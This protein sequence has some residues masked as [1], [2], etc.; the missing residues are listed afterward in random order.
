[1]FRGICTYEVSDLINN[2]NIN[3][4]SIGIPTRCLKLACP[5][6]SAALA[7]VFNLSLM[8][9]IVPDILKISKVTPID[10]GGEA[11]DPFNYRPISTLSQFTQVFEKLVYK[12]LISYIEKH[13]ILSEFQFGFRKGH[14]TEQAITEIVD[15]FRSSVDSNQIVCGV[16]LD[17]A[18]AF[19]TVN[20]SIL[21]K[22]LEK[23]G[24]RGSPLQW[25]TSYLSNRQQYVSL[26]H[27]Q[28]STKTVLCG[29]PQGSTLGPLLFLL[30]INDIANS[31][32]KLSFRLFA[33]DTNVFTSSKS[34]HELQSIMNH[35]LI[36]VKNWC[37][38][39]KLSINLKK[40]NFLIIKSTR[41]KL[42]TQFHIK[43]PCSD[44]DFFLEQKDSIKYLGVLIDDKL[45]W[46]KHISFISSKIS[47]NTGVFFKLRHYLSPTQLRQLYY[48]LIYP[49][50]SY[51]ITA[52]GTST[53]TNIKTLQTKQNHVVRVIFFASLYGKNTDS[54]LPYLNLLDILTIENIHKLQV[55]KSTLYW[56]K[57][58]LPEIFNDSFKYAKNVHSYNTRYAAKDNFY[59][60]RFRTNI[61]RQTLPAT[62][63]ILW[64][65]LPS[66]FKQLSIFRFKKEVKHYLLTKQNSLN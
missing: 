40:T 39:N 64:Q 66:K 21:L 4:A 3:K 37:D 54:A 51:A 10:K 9:G 12:Q 36:L 22:K 52:W 11:A 19:D 16:F 25:F 13:N 50:L 14:S 29:I 26:D 31:S 5:N 57:N 33:D 62:A 61:G 53:K 28:S 32:K 45:N 44:T 8:Q 35:E 1:M 48:T 20:H 30:Y 47:R 56:H 49:Y 65:D 60:T 41:K 24:I 6:V 2:L 18:K 34:Q 43:L 63:T 55:L 27:T 58:E 23:Y 59:K 17:F 7:A 46:K 42:T 15:S 38:T